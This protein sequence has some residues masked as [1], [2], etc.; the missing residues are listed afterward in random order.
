MSCMG[1]NQAKATI[2][3]RMDAVRD[4]EKKITAGTVVPVI[5]AQGGIAFKGWT[6]NRRDVS[7]ACAYRALGAMNSP[8]LRKAL[9][10]AEVMAG[11]KV[12]QRAVNSGQH[13]HDGGKTWGSH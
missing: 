10:R 1:M 5:S 8:A 2:A 3:E 13:S 4:L 9:A 6:E 12:D 11:R 7:D